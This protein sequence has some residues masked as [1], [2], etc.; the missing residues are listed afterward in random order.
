M[1]SIAK[2]AMDEKVAKIISIVTH[3]IFMLTWAMLIMFNQEAYFVMILPQKLRWSIILL[4]LGNTAILPAILIWIMAR[5]KLI[6]SLHMPLREE[7]TYPYIIFAIFYATTFYM[8]RN[9]GLPQVYYLFIAGGLAAIGV[10][11]V[12]NLFWKISIHMIGIG[13]LLG[14]FTALSFRMLID[15]PL[16]ILALIFVSGLT[17]FARLRSNSHSPA[18]VYVGFLT[19]VIVMGGIFLLL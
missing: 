10:T 5:Q 19:G 11:L 2:I 13:G 17:G 3:P 8:M 7:R 12:I 16:L 18:Q 1:E 9:L 15:A 14:G 4:T 6:S